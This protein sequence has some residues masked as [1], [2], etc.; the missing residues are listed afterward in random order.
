MPSL[1]IWRSLS[2]I[3]VS[4]RSY[5]VFI[6]FRSLFL[7][8]S[9][10]SL[11][12]DLPFS[13]ELPFLFLDHS[14]LFRCRPL[15]AVTFHA[16]S[17][18][19]VSSFRYSPSLSH[20]FGNLSPLPSNLN[21]HSAISKFSSFS[22]SSSHFY[23]GLPQNF[24]LVIIFLSSLSSCP[25]VFSLTALLSSHL[26]LRI[27]LSFSLTQ[28][29]TPSPRPSL[30]HISEPTLLYFHISSSLPASPN[31]PS[32]LNFSLPHSVPRCLISSSCFLISSALPSRLRFLSIFS[33][34]I[35]SPSN[36]FLTLPRNLLNSRYSWKLLVLPLS[37]S[38]SLLSHVFFLI[39][40]YRYHSLSL[41]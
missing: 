9:L 34:P 20:F 7:S 35:P 10:R 12:S 5:L 31:L 40:F 39:S 26:L 13:Y 32:I 11:F 23:L 14:S 19:L 2:L 37:H 25:H 17:F 27:F 8:S 6:L 3:F 16:F 36:S 33:F 21:L 38:L 41:F 29:L 22:R 30:S 28:S 24:C 15:L 1:L 18:L 4:H